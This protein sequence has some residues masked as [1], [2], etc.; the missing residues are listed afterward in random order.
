MRPRA[1]DLGIIIG[2]LPAGPYNAITD[3]PGVKVGHSTIVEGTG[4]LVPGAGPIR[5][6][7]TAIWPHSGDLFYDK[8][9]GW[10][11]TVNGFG[12]VTNAA[13]VFE[14]GA[15]EGPIV[16]TNT[17]NVPRV[18]DFVNDWALEHYPQMGITDWGISPNTSDASDNKQL[19]L[20]GGGS[21]STTRGAYIAIRGNE[22][23]TDG[24][25]L[26]LTGGDSG[27]VAAH[28]GGTTFQVRRDSS[29][30][31]SV[32]VG[33][34]GAV[35]LSG[36]GAGSAFSFSKAV[37]AAAGLTVSSG[38]TLTLTGATVTGLG[39]ASI[40]AGTFPAGSFS[41]PTLAVTSG[42]TLTGATITGTPTW[43]SSQAITLSTAAQASV[44]SLGT[45][46]A[47]AIGA[48]ST[49]NALI[50]TTTGAIQQSVRYDATHRLD[51]AIAATGA[52]FFYA[53][54]DAGAGVT[55]DSADSGVNIQ[56]DAGTAFLSF[57]NGGAGFAHNN[58]ADTLTLSGAAL[59]LNAATTSIP[60]VRLPHGTAPS[61]PTN[62]DMWT[63]TGG[64]YVRIN[65][66]TVGPLA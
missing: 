16:L 60:S 24:G 39:A 3:V 4:P 8:V 54:G 50:V 62:G 33:A 10:V 21:A 26:F 58:T 49:T 17:F 42:L 34:T 44:T 32:A 31:M 22:Y 14:M 48:G 19:V 53:E 52:A 25:A 36:L 23:A 2:S 57:D 51:V 38:Q 45:L 65:G 11:E 15:I 35:T 59:I 6:G 37:T 30:Y 13:Q 61:S 43:S 27:F 47:L 29:N 41:M 9:A 1:R 55:F 40:V 18:A 28:I 20:G 63:T 5:T 56:N 7:V 12:E 46:T 64:L 66:S